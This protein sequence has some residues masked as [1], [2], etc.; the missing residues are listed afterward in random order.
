MSSLV[1]SQVLLIWHM[2]TSACFESLS[3]RG[4]MYGGA[5]YETEKPGLIFRVITITLL[6]EFELGAEL[7]YPLLLWFDNGCSFCYMCFPWLM[8]HDACALAMNMCPFHGWLYLVNLYIK[9]ENILLRF[10]AFL[11][12]VPL[13]KIVFSVNLLKETYFLH[14]SI[15]FVLVWHWSWQYLCSGCPWI[16]ELLVKWACWHIG[17]RVPCCENFNRNF[18]TLWKDSKWT[19]ESRGQWC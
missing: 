1:V 3:Y 13:P 9:M 4:S 11:C 12:L 18:P 6:V 10:L 7:L 8:H 16:F 2:I 5:R 17:E 19:K 15:T 14:S